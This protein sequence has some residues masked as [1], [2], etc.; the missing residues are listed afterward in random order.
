MRWGCLVA[1]LAA[2]VG[3]SD[4]DDTGSGFVE[5]IVNVIDPPQTDAFVGFNT[6]CAFTGC[7]VTQD[8]PCKVSVCQRGSGVDPGCTMKQVGTG[9]V[10]FSGGPINMHTSPPDNDDSQD[11]LWSGGETFRATSTGDS[12][13]VPAFNETVTAPSPF[14]APE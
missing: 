4:A 12:A 9:A 7:T 6:D 1:V 5:L 10:T 2:C 8:G 11:V 14:T 13:G 3:D